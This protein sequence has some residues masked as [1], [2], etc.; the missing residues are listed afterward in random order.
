[1]ARCGQHAVGQEH[2]KGE[3]KRRG[4]RTLR[5]MAELMM[6]IIMPP[7]REA[8]QIHKSLLSPEVTKELHQCTH[9]RT[10]KL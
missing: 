7:S 10:V 2:A 6:M 9:R 4:G 1:M 3:E 5:F 8:A